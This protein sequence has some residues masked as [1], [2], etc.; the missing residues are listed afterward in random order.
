MQSLLHANYWTDIVIDLAH[1]W[2]LS[3]DVMNKEMKDNCV[4][5]DIKP[6]EQKVLVDYQFVPC[7]L[8]FDI[9]MNFTWKARFVAD[10]DNKMAEKVYATCKT[11][12]TMYTNSEKAEKVY[13]TC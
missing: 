1:S 9:Q 6:E 8:I 12:E 2:T 7:H 13:V 5:F 3:Q 11:L 4:A 10:V